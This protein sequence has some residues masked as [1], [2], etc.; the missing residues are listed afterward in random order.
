MTDL[1]KI[2]RACAVAAAF[3]A[4]S[5]TAAPVTLTFEGLGDFHSVASFYAGG[6]ST[7]GNS[8][9]DHGIYF[10]SSLHGLVDV[11]SDP[12]AF[13]LFANNP[14]GD[15]VLT[16]SDDRDSVVSVRQGFQNVFSF[17]YAADS[18]GFV[19]VYEDLDGTGTLLASI[20]LSSS[21]D[22]C[23]FDNYFCNFRSVSLAFSGTARSVVFGGPGYGFA[24][25]DLT[26]DIEAAPSEVPEPAT[27]G[28]TALGLAGLVA[29]RR[30]ARAQR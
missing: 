30:K 28:L 19:N 3:A 27:L 21:V 23:D 24:F 22:G 6:T 14:S 15:T 8:G 13:G 25:D 4:G 5:A 2:A 9:P 16:F 20:A 7:S 10:G 1:K 11:D 12:N 29:A 17:Y 18:E 26:F